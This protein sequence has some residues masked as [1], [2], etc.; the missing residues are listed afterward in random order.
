VIKDTVLL[1][2]VMIAMTVSW[3]EEA[4][5]VVEP[6]VVAPVVCDTWLVGDEKEMILL[7]LKSACDVPP[8]PDKAA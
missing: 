5:V 1:I 3:A 4:P 6:E 8:L 7:E 2:L